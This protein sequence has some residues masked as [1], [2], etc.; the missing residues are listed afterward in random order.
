MDE[1]DVFDWNQHNIAHI[2]RHKVSPEEAEQ[3]LASDPLYPDFTP[4]T[5]NGEKRWT[6]YGQTD[7]SRCLVVIYTERGSRFRF[8]TAYPMTARQRKDYLRWRTEQSEIED[9]E[10][11]TYGV[12][13]DNDEDSE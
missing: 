7:Q 2:R 5:V 13:E 9:D 10:Y 12:S 1:G 4:E 3:V 11:E 8:V 6:A